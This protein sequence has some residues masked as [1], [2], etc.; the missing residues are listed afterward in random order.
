MDLIDEN[1][2]EDDG[3]VWRGSPD[4][5]DITTRRLLHKINSN[6]SLEA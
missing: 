2:P 5:L 3:R 4:R 1:C 6:L